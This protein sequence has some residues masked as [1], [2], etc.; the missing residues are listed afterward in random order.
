MYCFRNT[1]PIIT[2]TYNNNKE[3]NLYYYSYITTFDKMVHPTTIEDYKNSMS[4]HNNYL[5]NPPSSNYNFIKNDDTSVET[6]DKIKGINTT[7]TSENNPTMGDWDPAETRVFDVYPVNDTTKKM[8]FLDVFSEEFHPKLSVKQEFSQSVGGSTTTSCSSSDSKSKD[9][10]VS[11]SSTTLHHDKLSSQR[12]N[13][14]IQLTPKIEVNKHMTVVSPIDAISNNNTNR[15]SDTNTTGFSITGP[16]IHSAQNNTNTNDD[17]DGDSDSDSSNNSH[18]GRSATSN[19]SFS[20]DTTD[21]WSSDVEDAFLASLKLIAKKGTSKIKLLDKNYGRNELISLYIYYHTKEF[22]T[23]K[24]IS[25][26]IQVWK[27]AINSKKKNNQTITYSE[28]ELFHLIQN[29]APKSQE[30]LDQFNSEFKVIVDKLEKEAS[31]DQNHQ[32]HDTFPMLGTSM[33]RKA[34]SDMGSGYDHYNSLITPN[35]AG[36]NSKSKDDLG[37]DGVTNIAGPTYPVDY[38]K[39][40]YEKM[41]DYKCLPLSIENSNAY[42]PFKDPHTRV[43][44][45][46]GDIFR[47]KSMS[48]S[49]A[50]ENAQ[51]IERKQRNLIEIV[52][53]ALQSPNN[54]TNNTTIVNGPNPAINNSNF[55]KNNF[56]GNAENVIPMSNPQSSNNYMYNNGQ[57][58]TN[59]MPI[60][61]NVPYHSD[62]YSGQPQSQWNNNSQYSVVPPPPQPIDRRASQGVVADLQGQ[63]TQS[64]PMASSNRLSTGFTPAEPNFPGSY[65]P[66]WFSPNNQPPPTSATQYNFGPSSYPPM[67]S[68]LDNKQMRQAPPPHNGQGSSNG[69]HQSYYQYQYQSHIYVLGNA[70]SPA[71]PTFNSNKQSD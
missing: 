36:Y 44:K 43:N 57:P 52:G 30:T 3:D 65:P 14:L 45:S 58:S 27:K 20:R 70:T 1:D 8:P 39:N 7:V 59:I 16:L 51:Q 37:K 64:F 61:G 71:Y 46:E 67:P 40:M 4:Q 12:K 48:R 50:I 56:T 23:K 13:S 18:Y 68:S 24:Q 6:E 60:S 53:K 11:N 42:H 47:K 10:T 22:R 49:E 33:R 26:H 34:T 55:Y 2:T 69:Q 25:S 63:P 21:K 9:H 41:P 31:N 38:A 62:Y 66:P 5:N 15:G 32:L 29:G 19:S 28:L 17:N 54:A 35:S